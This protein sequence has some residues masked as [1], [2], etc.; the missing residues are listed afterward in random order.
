MVRGLEGSL[1]KMKESLKRSQNMP[2]CV[3]SPPGLGQILAEA[4][5]EAEPTYLEGVK[6]EYD[7]RRNVVYNRL[8]NIKGVVSYK[9]GGAFY[10]F[11]R[12]PVENAEHFCKWLL[13]DF[14]YN[15]ATLML[16]PGE[17]FYATPGL[18]KDE[19]RLAYILNVQ[20]L[21]AAMDC[22]EQAL[23]VYPGTVKVEASKML[24]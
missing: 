10:C 2:N 9:P 12:F 19:V 17:G 14:S 4:T 13:Q 21:H 1:Q 24:A 23:A 11:A 15:G 5:L 6:E 16:S 7:K 3:L 18:G 8:Q 22:L 20:D